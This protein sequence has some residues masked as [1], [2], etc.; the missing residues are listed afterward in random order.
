MLCCCE[1]E[2]CDGKEKEELTKYFE[3][4][5]C[6]KRQEQTRLQGPSL[7]QFWSTYY[8][9]GRGQRASHCVLETA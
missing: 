2:H 7:S 6:S 8:I 9:L 3:N 4:A 1:W 5:G